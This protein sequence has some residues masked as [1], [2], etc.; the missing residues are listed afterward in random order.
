M[1]YLE[2]S[3]VGQ[4]EVNAIVQ[5]K[6]LE[7]L[8]PRLMEGIAKWNAD[9]Q[10]GPIQVPSAGGSTSSHQ[11]SLDMVTPPPSIPVVQPMELDAPELPPPAETTKA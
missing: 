6:I 5:Q 11:V 7:M 8:P 3:K 1:A 2:A 9:G 10:V 4:D